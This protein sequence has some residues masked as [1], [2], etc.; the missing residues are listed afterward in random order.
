MGFDYSLDELHT[1]YI[2]RYISK[3]HKKLLDCLV[4]RIVSIDTSYVKYI[5]NFLTKGK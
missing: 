4:N 1:V 2:N 3:L 5:M